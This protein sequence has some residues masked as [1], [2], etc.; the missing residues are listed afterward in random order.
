MTPGHIEFPA[1][2]AKWYIGITALS[3]TMVASL[4][5]G[6]AFIVTAAQLVGYLRRDRS[7]DL[8][9]KQIQLLHVCIYNI[10]TIVA[11]GLVFGLSGLYPQFWSQL[12]VHQFWTLIVEEFLFF[13][14]A[15]TLTLH[16]FFWDKLWGHKKMHIFLGALLTPFFLL[17]F[18]LINGIGA[19]MLT[20][21]F[22]EAQASLSQ[23]ILGWDRK[24]FYNPSF[25]MLTL[26]RAFV[27]FSYGGFMVAGLCGWH[28]F[29]KHPVPVLQ[30]Y[31]KGGRFAFT[32]GFMAFLSL[33]IIG[34]FYAHVL[35]YEANEAFVNLMWGKGDIIAGGIDWWWLKHLIVALMF[36]M[37]MHYFWRQ[38]GEDG[39]LSIPA[40]MVA[41]IALFYLMF[42]LAMG[43]IMTYAFFW[44]MVFTALAGILLAQ[45]LS[46]YHQGSPRALFTAVA[47]L[48]L[49]TVLLG[50]YAREAA[51]P[52]FV[53][54][55]SHYDA[56]YPP[57]QR[58][59]Y[60]M[61]PLA[62][63]DLP[64]PS[65]AVEATPAPEPVRL[66]RQK[67]IGCHTL[68]RVKNYRAGDWELIVGQMQAYGLR[69]STGEAAM[70][71]EHLRSGK[72][73]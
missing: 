60:L 58:Q 39:L 3:H 43:M 53:N 73:Y 49:L 50:G 17:Q 38:R 9:A 55:I 63:A 44:W 19:F 2:G 46:G 20:P 1:I 52:R 65:P 62:P 29:R 61:L 57:H 5:I 31:E 18:Y 15:T 71:V 23:G 59:P 54:R 16:Y 66:I 34:Y 36:G 70:I 24:A 68:E 47:L 6:F 41:A 67:C 21:G 14:L 22:G 13:L 72:P 25:L 12:F 51:R 42:Y 26:H 48:S 11:I 56:I 27:N 33:P 28:L 45:H 10:G 32:L 40:V 8:L 30:A 37:T 69:L 35:K 4:S 7:Y 64:T